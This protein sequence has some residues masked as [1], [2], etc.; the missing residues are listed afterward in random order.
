MRIRSE[1]NSD[2]YKYLLIFSIYIVTSVLLTGLL[3]SAFP[4]L[5][6]DNKSGP[7]QERPKHVLILNSHNYGMP[8]QQ[9]VNQA[10]YKAFKENSDINTKLHAEFTG[11]S[12]NFDPAYVKILLDLYEHK[13]AGRNMDLIIAVDVSA[14]DFLINHGQTLFPDVPIVF[15]SAARDMK[16]IGIRAKITGLLSDLDVK[17]TLELAIKLHPEAKQYATISG[18]SAM[19]RLYESEARSVF[20]DYQDRFEFIDLTGLPMDE[21]LSRVAELPEHTIGI[22]ILTLADGAGNAFIPRDILS[23]IS[24]ASSVPMYGL[25]D[26]LLGGGIVGGRVS[27]AEVEGA[28]IAEMGLRILNGEKPEDIPII[29][30]SNVYMFDWRQLQ[31]WGI[32]ESR[33]PAESIVRFREYSFWELNKW[34]IMG[35]LALLVIETVLILGLLIHRA[36]RRKAEQELR[37]AHDELEI[38]VTDRT[39]ELTRVNHHLQREIAE[40]KLA[41]DRIA[42]FA[43]IFEDS[44]N[45]IYL[46]E[47]ESLNFTHVNS[48]AQKNLGYSMDE[49]RKLTPIDLKPEFTPEYFKKIISPLLK[50]EKEKIVFETVHQR[51]DQSLYNVEVHL[52]LL[53]Y[54][55]EALFAAIIL[56][57]SDRKRAE[58]EQEKLRDQL[59]Q[60]E[61]LK[62]VG[63]L[64]GG[65]AHDFNNLLQAIA[66]YTLIILMDKTENDPDYSKLKGIQSASDSAAKLVRQLLQFSRKVESERRPLNLNRELEKTRL[67]LEE[68]IAEDIKIELYLDENLWDVN[69]DPV[70]IEQIIKNL[71]TN[72]AEAMT[73]G[74]KLI[75]TTENVT[76][77][78]DY[79]QND[80]NVQ[81]GNYVIL[82]FSDTGHGMDQETMAHI[83]EPFF[84]TKEIG[85]GP[86]LGLASVYGIV[87]SY[88]GHITCR[89]EFGHGADFK[90][91]LPAVNQN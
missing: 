66:G 83:F 16:K 81:P 71:G 47:A 28:Q 36:R 48:A 42:R 56:D 61:K 76:L 89:S 23:Q 82:T 20:K 88:G 32:S 53:K 69:A 86:G 43:H 57:I 40:R 3:A 44:L 9:S 45:E 63:T 41:E 74:G 46:F 37:T 85:Q 80:L 77:S 73:N 38:R 22:Y 15:I 18:S 26:S 13:Y 19:D 54:G 39:V 79:S 51:K 52:Q 72:A 1:N 6:A 65:V 90:I 14:T 24:K 31:R 75:I 60:A 11:L 50:A 17:G 67:L 21:L 7:G 29:K 35:V 12:Q 8:W 2:N 49:F 4:A 59:Q 62:A 33:L 25:W 64:A 84:S 10:I 78:E 55:T 87:K 30:G 68:K 91:Y 27:S 5:A 70:Q 58:A 34:K